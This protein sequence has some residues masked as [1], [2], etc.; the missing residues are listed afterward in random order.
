MLPTKA[1][2]NWRRTIGALVLTLGISACGAGEPKSVGLTGVAYNYSQESF[3][4]VKVNGK[5]VGTALEAV[6]PGAVGGGSM[7]CFM[8][9]VGTK[10][11][12]VYFEPAEGDGYTLTATIEKWWPDLAHYGVVHILPGR[13]VVMQVTPS[14]P[15][16]RKDLLE[17]QQRALGL[18]VGTLFQMW[19]AGPRERID[20]KE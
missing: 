18:P 19:S 2:K 12:E 20:G 11:V 1:A 10:Q 15:L 16:P 13:K 9:P 4:W 7:C 14:A 17:A 5:T 6:V 8:L 3:A